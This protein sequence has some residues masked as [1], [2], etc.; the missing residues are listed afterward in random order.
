MTCPSLGHMAMQYSS[1]S[2]NSFL[3]LHIDSYDGE[4]NFVAK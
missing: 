4:F 1:S 3:F 2:S